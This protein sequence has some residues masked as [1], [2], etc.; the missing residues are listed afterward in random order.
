[1]LRSHA[2]KDSKRGSNLRGNLRHLA[3]YCTMQISTTHTRLQ[4]STSTAVV[5]AGV[6]D[7]LDPTAVLGR[8]HL[9]NIVLCTEYDAAA[10]APSNL[11]VLH[12]SISTHARTRTCWL[13][14]THRINC[15]LHRS[16]YCVLGKKYWSPG[17]SS[18]RQV[19]DQP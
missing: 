15:H 13:P 7:V 6:A 8:W 11:A 18:P 19:V 10:D 3:W 17:Q 1:M 16:S 9:H 14:S 12:Q 5:T 4:T 2:K